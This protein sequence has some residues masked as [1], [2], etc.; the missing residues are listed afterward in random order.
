MY[1]RKILL[2]LIRI[3][4]LHHSKEEKGIYGVGIIQELGRHGYNISP[5]TLYPILHEMQKNKLLRM[6][7]EI[8]NGKIRKIYRITDIG[9]EIL[10]EMKDFVGELYREVV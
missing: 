7:E 6:K 3:H 1:T 10:E 8:V 9:N 4:I 5:G 2:G